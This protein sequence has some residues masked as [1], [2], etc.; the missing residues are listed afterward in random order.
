MRL[1]VEFIELVA[2]SC[3]DEYIRLGAVRLLATMVLL[4]A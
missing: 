1:I 2:L 4:K 3:R